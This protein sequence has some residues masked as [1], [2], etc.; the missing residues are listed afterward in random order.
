MLYS[1]NNQYPKPLPFRIVL[2]DG[3][4][5]TDPTSF[6]QEEIASAGFVEVP[7]PP[8]ADINQVI[9]WANG[10]WLL[11]ERTAEELALDEARIADAIRKHRNNLLIESDWTQVLDA[12]VDQLAWKTYR[13]ALRDITAQEGFPHVII[14][15]EPPTLEPNNDPSN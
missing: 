6:T 8:N 11:R 3:T 13:Q 9:E 7:Y 10:S 4:T 1:Y 14:W 5:R 2:S 12:P 15:P